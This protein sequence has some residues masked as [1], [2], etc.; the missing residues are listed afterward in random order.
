MNNI[1]IFFFLYFFF[2]D[3]MRSTKQKIS[4]KLF[5]LRILFELKAILNDVKIVLYYY[6]FI[7]FLNYY[8]ILKYQFL[9]H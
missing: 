8:D 9:Y 3:Q 5:L 2:L 6:L 4:C 7:Y 1:Y